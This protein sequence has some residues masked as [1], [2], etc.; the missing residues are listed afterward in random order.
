MVSIQ[1]MKRWNTEEAD[2]SLMD[3]REVPCEFQLYDR[4]FSVVSHSSRLRNR[5]HCCVLDWS[6]WFQISFFPDSPEPAEWGE[7][8]D[9]STSCGA[10]WRSRYRQCVNCDRNHFQNVQSQPCVINY[11][12]PRKFFHMYNLILRSCCCAV[13]Q[14]LNIQNGGSLSVRY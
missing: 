9:C 6:Y 7:W 11:Y 14:S 12:C 4:I 10:G 1:S 5:H 13:Y 2:R 8:G 3:K